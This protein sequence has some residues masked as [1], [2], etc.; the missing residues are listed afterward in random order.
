[1]PSMYETDNSFISGS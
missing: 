1:M